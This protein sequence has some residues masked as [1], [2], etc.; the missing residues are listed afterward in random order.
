VAVKV[1]K[2]TAPAFAL[3]IFATLSVARP[4]GIES[5]N[6]GT[7]SLSPDHQ[8]SE[9]S[10]TDEDTAVIQ[11]VRNWIQKNLEKAWPSGQFRGRDPQPASPDH[12]FS[13]PPAL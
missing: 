8:A 13:Y 12:D 3:L 5:L 11:L 9:N 1:S 7:F 10:D 2:Q 4:G 6:F